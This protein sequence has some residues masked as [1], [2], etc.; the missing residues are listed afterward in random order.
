MFW[1]LSGGGDIYCD[2]MTRTALGIRYVLKMAGLD[3]PETTTGCVVEEDQWF[4]EFPMELIVGTGESPLRS[5]TDLALRA[6]VCVKNLA[7]K[8][9][10]N[11]N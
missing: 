7:K 2:L 6:F 4:S 8:D 3:S 9:G 5:P 10:D 11:A 1:G